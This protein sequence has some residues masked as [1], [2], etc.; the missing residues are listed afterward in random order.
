[1]KRLFLIILTLNLNYSLAK[2]GGNDIFTS[3]QAMKV[4]WED[5]IELVNKLETIVQNMKEVIPHMERYGQLVH[6]E[7]KSEKS[8]I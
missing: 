7:L 2:Y 6:N 3:L 1:M 4:L 5:D 8:A